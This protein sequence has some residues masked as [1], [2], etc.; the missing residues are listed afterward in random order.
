MKDGMKLNIFVS[1]MI[2][3]SIMAP[4]SVFTSFWLLVVSFIIF[5][6]TLT[7]LRFYEFKYETSPKWVSREVYN[8]SI[9]EN[10][11]RLKPWVTWLIVINAV[12]FV[13][14]MLLAGYYEV[15]F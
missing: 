13:V 10:E 6:T 1:L 9:G 11:R 7:F 14:S 3:G 8:E 2:I 12:I 15:S 5:V 4:V